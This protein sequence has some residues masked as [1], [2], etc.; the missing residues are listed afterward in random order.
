MEDYFWLITIGVV[1]L[2]IMIISSVR[3]R[4]DNNIRY[5]NRQRIEMLDKGHYRKESK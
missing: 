1:I 3:S 5:S 4:D 2:I